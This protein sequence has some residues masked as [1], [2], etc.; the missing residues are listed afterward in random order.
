M[1]SQLFSTF[2]L[3]QLSTALLPTDGAQLEAAAQG[4]QYDGSSYG[5]HGRPFNAYIQFV[6]EN[7]P[8]K[9]DRDSLGVVTTAKS[10]IVVDAKTGVLLYGEHPYDVRSIGSVTKLMSVMVFLDTAPNLD[11]I[12]E[13]DPKTDLVGGGKQYVAFY[14]GV[15]IRDLLGAILIGSD[16][17]GAQSLVRL[18]GMTEVQFVEKMNEKASNL[19]LSKTFFTDP[20]GIR[21]TNVSTAYDLSKL[22]TATD[23]YKDM[24]VFMGSAAYAFTQSSGHEVLVE[25][26]NDALRSYQGDSAYRIVAG[27]TGYLPEAGYV[28]ASTVESRGKRVQVIVMGSDSK[29]LRSIEMRG[30]A[31]WA[32]RVFRWP[33]EV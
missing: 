24:H 14:D 21:A 22:L 1:L 10:S 23:A 13:L 19:G 9:I 16:N 25:N 5:E 8:I 33:S 20:T 18:S 6:N 31:E 27:K 11:S 29:E 32:F 28:L 30:L 26:T 7:A 2:F 12:V 17:S 4:Q 15:A 3:H